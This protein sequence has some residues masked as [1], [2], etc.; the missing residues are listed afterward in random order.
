MHVINEG[1]CFLSFLKVTPSVI[2]SLATATA[3]R[4]LSLAKVLIKLIFRGGLEAAVA[5]MP[6]YVIWF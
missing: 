1:M 4:L 2:M 3:R 6:G 5:G